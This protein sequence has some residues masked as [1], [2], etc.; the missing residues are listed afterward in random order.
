MANFYWR[1]IG[2]QNIKMQLKIQMKT[3]KREMKLLKN[4]M[5]C[6]KEC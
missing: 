2:F 6:Q 3:F 1:Q 4:Y 5:K